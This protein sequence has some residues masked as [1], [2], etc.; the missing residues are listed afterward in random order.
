MTNQEVM[1][2]LQEGMDKICSSRE[3]QGY[4]KLS[5]CFPSYSSRNTLLI[6]TQCPQATLV[7]GFQAWKK[8]NRHVK[9]G[10][11]A[12]RILAPCRTHVENEDGQKEEVITRFRPVSVFDIS[13]TEGEP[14][15]G[16]DFYPRTLE[17]D[18]PHYEK[19]L[20]A[21]GRLTDFRIV[22]APLEGCNGRCSYLDRTI[23]IRQGMPQM[24]TIKT[25]L[26]EIGHAMLHGFE[27]DPASNAFHLHLQQNPDCKEIEAES[28]AFLTCY[29]CLGIDSQDFSFAYIA[30][31]KKNHAFLEESLKRIMDCF[32]RISRKLEPMLEEIL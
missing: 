24:Q 14:L 29:K 3:F 13:Q 4:L 18:V 27:L 30:G 28:V 17:G 6:Y 21:L 15:A 1:Q 23:S 19:I 20:E 11:R 10:S 2:I 25:L 26:H 9:K 16:A 31:Y 8:L 32:S 12:L 5:T 22:F 7:C